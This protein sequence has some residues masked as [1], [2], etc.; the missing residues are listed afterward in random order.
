MNETKKQNQTKPNQ[1]TLFSTFWV[2]KQPTVH[3][4]NKSNA[5]AHFSGHV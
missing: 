5:L 3:V 4:A 1:T 2:S